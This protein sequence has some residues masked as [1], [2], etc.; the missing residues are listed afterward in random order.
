MRLNEAGQMVH[1]IWNDLPVRYPDIETDEFV[2]MPNHVHGIIVIVGAGPCA[3]PGIHARPESCT[4]QPQTG[5]PQGVAPTT[6]SLPDTVHHFKSFT[7]AEYRNGVRLQHWPPFNSK[8]WQ[9]NYYEHIIRS[10]DEMNR[11]RT[12]IIENPAKWAEDEDNPANMDKRV[13]SPDK[14]ERVRTFYE[15]VIIS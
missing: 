10:E 7:T 15:P 6:L 1:N 8:L 9:R 4:A 2:V 3:C 13:K 12:Y 11:I 14:E 5:Q